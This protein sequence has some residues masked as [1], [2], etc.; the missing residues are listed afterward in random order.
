MG[1]GKNQL[2]RTLE[3]GLGHLAFRPQTQQGLDETCF[4]GEGGS[5]AG[6]GN[7]VVALPQRRA[8]GV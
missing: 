3:L 7:G 1:A 6:N 5:E 4:L 8:W 2:P